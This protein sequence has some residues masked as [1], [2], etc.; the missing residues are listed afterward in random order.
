MRLNTSARDIVLDDSIEGNA[1]SITDSL[2]TSILLTRN[3]GYYTL[4]IGN[5]QTDY[6]IKVWK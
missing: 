6:E 4:N 5:V 2:G 1:I 3:E